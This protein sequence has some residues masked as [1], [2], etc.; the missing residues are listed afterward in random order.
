[1]AFDVFTVITSMSL[2][3]GYSIKMALIQQYGL[4]I[5]PGYY[6]FGWVH[7]GANAVIFYF[8][9]ELLISKLKKINHIQQPTNS[10]IDPE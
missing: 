8:L 6:P 2:L 5:P 9:A 10:T 4:I 3:F 7:L 1:M